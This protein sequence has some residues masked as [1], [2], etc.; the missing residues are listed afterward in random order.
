MTFLGLNYYSV[1]QNINISS[2]PGAQNTCVPTLVHGKI[3]WPGTCSLAN[4]YLYKVEHLATLLILK[5]FSEETRK[6]FLKFCI[7]NHMEFP[8]WKK[9]TVDLAHT[10]MNILSFCFYTTQSALPNC[11]GNFCFPVSYEAVLLI[12]SW[13]LIAFFKTLAQLLPNSGSITS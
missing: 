10:D 1:S 8:V 9:S 6:I 11:Q 3:I 5:K 4:T 12:T 13:L 7:W 2:L